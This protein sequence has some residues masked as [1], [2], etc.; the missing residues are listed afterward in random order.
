MCEDKTI[1]Y[2]ERHGESLGNLNYIFLGHTD[3]GLSSLGHIQ[4]QETCDALSDVHFDAIYSSDLIRAFMT[5]KPHAD[6]RGVE[7]IPSVQLREIYCGEWENKGKEYIDDNY[8]ELYNVEW[9]HNF[10]MFQMPGGESVEDVIHRIEEELLRIASLHKG[11]TVLVVTHAAVIRA[12]YSHI[13]G[14]PRELVGEAT[15]FPTN[16]SYSII[17][18]SDGKFTPIEYSCD[19][20]ILT[21]VPLKF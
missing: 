21:N 14:I 18:F 1:I 10:G 7:V 5:A 15:V 13:S 20:H 12:F 2:L 8:H 11:G 4:A 17:E 19:S 9:K 16:A 6:L 3:L